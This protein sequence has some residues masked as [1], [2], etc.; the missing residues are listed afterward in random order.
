MDSNGHTDVD[1]FIRSLHLI[2]HLTQH[3]FE[4]RFVEEA[5]E[6]PLSFVHMNLLRILDQ[7]PGKTV[8]DIATFMDVSY[9]AATKTI[10][11]LV[12]LGLLKRREDTKDRRIAHLLLTPSGKKMVEKYHEIKRERMETILKAF[13]VGQGKELSDSLQSFARTLVGTYPIKKGVCL[14]CGAFNPDEC[15]TTK[16][17]KSCGY[18]DCIGK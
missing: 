17:E 12:K 7:H 16:D 14:H 4:G 2:S 13:G 10:D 3:Y 6:R 15:C 8:G 5:T 11:K 9:P 18:L 1:N